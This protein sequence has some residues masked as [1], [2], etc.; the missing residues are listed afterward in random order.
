LQVVGHSIL[1]TISA[2]S[3]RDAG[4]R[5][6]VRPIS[7]L[8]LGEIPA[9]EAEKWQEYYI[10]GL[11]FTFVTASDDFKD[12]AIAMFYAP[13]PSTDTTIVGDD[14]L[15][16]A[17]S[18]T[19][20]I[21]TKISRNM[22][23][24]V[25]DLEG[26]INPD[27]TN[28]TGDTRMETRGLFQVIVSDEIEEGTLGNIYVDYDLEFVGQGLSYTLS[29]ANTATATF[30]WNLEDTNFPNSA[31]Y[32]VN[33]DVGLPP[34]QQSDHGFFTMSSYPSEPD[35]T[36]VGV[37]TSINGGYA[38]VNGDGKLKWATT[39]DPTIDSIKSGDSYFFNVLQVPNDQWGTTTRI[40][41]CKSMNNSGPYEYGPDQLVTSGTNFSGANP[42]DG[43]IQMD[44][45]WYKNL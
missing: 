43:T 26:E 5:L 16:H 21:S 35:V 15:Q 36:L 37:V 33:D 29:R 44:M 10:R 40:Y 17:S 14:N 31:L 32:F 18:F 45:Y 34:A 25:T 1:G 23:L 19:D 41:P 2:Y 7:P 11:R 6:F 22:V 38:P 9:S 8:S 4:E 13:D 42:V 39:G 28:D 12:G 27:Y 24:D 3:V 30:Q 20:F